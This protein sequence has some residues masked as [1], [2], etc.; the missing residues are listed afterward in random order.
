MTL[1]VIGDQLYSG[2]CA[3]HSRAYNLVRNGYYVGKN[4][5]SIWLQTTQ[6]QS[7]KMQDNMKSHNRSE[8]ILGTK[9]R[10]TEEVICM[11]IFDGWVGISWAKNS[12][13]NIQ[14][15]RIACANILR[16]RKAW[17]ILRTQKS[18]AQLVYGDKVQQETGL[19]YK[20]HL[21]KT[22]SSNPWV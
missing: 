19:E 13:K 8:V 20:H 15:E 18:I 9:R 12:E 22:D 21:N 2:Y 5:N 1:N 14:I 3:R 10:F 17:Y 7:F 6:M 16:H 4:A 11:L